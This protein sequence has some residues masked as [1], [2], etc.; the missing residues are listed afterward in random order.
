MQPRNLDDSLNLEDS[1]TIDLGRLLTTRQPGPAAEDAAPPE[2]T[3]NRK[4]ADSKSRELLQNP[5][6]VPGVV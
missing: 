6:D 2:L 4:R 3:G 1:G 5:F